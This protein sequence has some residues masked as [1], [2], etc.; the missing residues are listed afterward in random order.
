MQDTATP[1]TRAQFSS[2][3]L[4]SKLP[5]QASNNPLTFGGA[6]DVIALH[7]R[8]LHRLDSAVQVKVF[9]HFDEFHVMDTAQF[10]LLRETLQ[11]DISQ[12]GLKKKNIG[13]V[14]IFSGVAARLLK[15]SVLQQTGLYKF[16]QSNFD[17]LIPRHLQLVEMFR[18]VRYLL[19][20]IDQ[21]LYSH[22]QSMELLRKPEFQR[23]IASCSGLPRLAEDLV[24]IFKS[25]Q[26][27][28]KRSKEAAQEHTEVSGEITSK[29]EEVKEGMELQEEDVEYEVVWSG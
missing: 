10:R 20:L 29:A 22:K 5:P 27:R 6:L 24:A 25:Q 1:V 4:D 21:P 28:M 17:L 15:G 7:F 2:N 8:T 13:L 19:E 16:C 11:Q 18:F 9:L 14:P 26:R 23:A 3:I 12:I